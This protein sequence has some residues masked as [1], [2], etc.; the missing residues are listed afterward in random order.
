M[1][2]SEPQQV[3]PDFQGRHF[4]FGPLRPEVANHME[5]R[6]FPT[7]FAIVGVLLMHMV[8][9]PTPALAM[10]PSVTTLPNGFTVLV[11]EDDRFPLASL[12]LYVRA[13][14]AYETPEQAGISHLLEHMVFKGTEK[15]PAG[16]IAQDVEG[17]GGYINAATSFDYTVY[18]TDMPVEH[19]HLGMEVLHDM[20]FGAKIDPEELEREKKVVLAELKRNEDTPQSLIFKKIQPLIWPDTP[21]ERPIIGFEEVVSATTRQDI[22]DYIARFYQP[23][24]MLLVVC[25][26]VE[27]DEVLAQATELFGSLANDRDIERAEP[28]KLTALRATQQQTPRI[29]AMQGDWNKTYLS[30]SFPLPSFHAAQTA[31]LEVLAQLLGGDK[32]SRLYRTF[33]YDKQ[34]V[35][36]ISASALTLERAGMLYIHASLDND[37]LDTFWKELLQ[38][39]AGLGPDD[40]SDQELERAKLNLEDSLFQ[41]KET[42]SGL[43]SKLGFFQFFEDGVVSEENYLYELRHVDREE[44]GTAMRDY[45]RPASLA[46][47]V[48][49][50]APEAPHTKEAL[51]T[52]AAPDTSD[53]AQSVDTETEKALQAELDRVWPVKKDATQLVQEEGKASGPEAIALAPGKTLVLIPDTTLPYTSLNLSL[54]GGDSLLPPSEQGLAA[55]TAKSLVKSTLDRSANELQDY[56]SD[57]AAELDSSASRD[58]VAVNVKFPTRFSDELLPLL[59]EILTR[60]AFAPEEVEREKTNQIAAIKSREDQPLGLAFRNVFPFLF[61]DHPYNYFHL[62]TPENVADYTP[63]QVRDFWEKQKQGNWTMAVCGDFDPAAIRELAQELAAAMG[64]E[65]TVGT[66]ENAPQWA[67]ERELALQLPNRNQ[68]HLLQIYK[69]PPLDHKDTAGLIL[70]REILAGQ[71]GL[72]FTRLRD[73]QGLGYSVTSFTWQSPSA[74]FMAFYIGTY[75]DKSTQALKGFEEVVAELHKTPLDNEAVQRGKNLLQGDYYREHQSLSSRSREAAS[76]S[77]LGRPLDA[78]VQEI[79]KAQKLTGADLQAL[80][81]KY[82]VP[83]TSYLL[84]VRP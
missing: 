24:T 58:T 49:T 79:A 22:L 60:P 31:T 48:L 41:A 62:G 76:L 2:E 38:E 7:L 11:Q 4:N 64:P 73:E 35:H 28:V 56:L 14:S 84:T 80:A 53:T 13:G 68:T 75:P 32:T 54:R 17:A 57:H 16:R 39:L 26:K 43:A 34:L 37:K 67:E 65:G 52:E 23:Q 21:Y 3:R 30:V 33:K 50:P 20:I 40:F 82:L 1:H 66:Q 15:R 71:S 42:L 51:N 59:R 29:T 25:G 6:M 70:L 36:D 27:T 72:L 5:H 78:N 47:V 83:E 81:K 46:S 19:W 9:A 77:V 8:L 63:E 10:E 61:K 12:R 69:I 18:M 55:L 74:G 44:L 45:L